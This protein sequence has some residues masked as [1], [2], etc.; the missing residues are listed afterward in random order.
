M[1]SLFAPN[2]PSSPK[3]AVLQA[4]A[5]TQISTKNSAAKG[6]RRVMI[7]K[8]QLF[9]ILLLSRLASAFVFPQTG[10]F[11]GTE[12]AAL[13]TAEGIRLLL[14]L[15]VIIYSA[16]GRNLYGAAARKS[17]FLGLSMSAVTGAAAVFLAAKTVFS[18][19]EYARSTIITGVY[20]AVIALIIA[21]FA[22]YAAAKGVEAIA[23]AG[24][25]FLVAAAVVTLAVVLSD[26]P[27][28]RLRE[29]GGAELS[30]GFV[31]QIAEQLLRGG[32][33]LIFSALLPFVKQ[34]GAGTMLTFAVCSVSAVILVGIFS[35]SVLGEFFAL[36]E[37]PFT[38]AAQLAD[39]ILFKRLDGFAAA[40][41]TLGAA[42]RAGLL[43]LSAY[44]AISAAAE[45]PAEK[46]RA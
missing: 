37:Y 32:E 4:Q 8:Y 21:A 2:V 31:Y 9:C 10:G 15:P 28:M 13:L 6:E 34:G 43:L 20:S 11:T 41:W 29:I 3:T 45:R 39:V 40:V 5:A 42:L 35:M 23:R 30:D 12:F 22:V 46:T 26:I 38:S 27:Y 24:V 14:A 25:L 19:A 1:H 7:S 16:K 33:Y 17:R 44:T 36:T 18:A